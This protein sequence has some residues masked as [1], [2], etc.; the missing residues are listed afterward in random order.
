MPR[1]EYVS[2]LRFRDTS[3]RGRRRAGRGRGP[4]AAGSPAW[5]RRP[6]TDA[7]SAAPR[8][9][10]SS[11]RSGTPNTH[12]DPGPPPRARRSTRVAA[13]AR[14]IGPSGHNRGRR[15]SSRASAG[16]VS[17]S[18]ARWPAMDASSHGTIA[19][20]G[21]RPS[22]ARD[23]SPGLQPASRLVRA[24]I[25]LR[26]ASG[27]EATRRRRSASCSSTA[28]STR[29]SCAHPAQMTSAR[30]ACVRS[31]ARSCSPS[32]PRHSPAGPCRS[33]TTIAAAPIATD[34]SALP[35]SSASSGCNRSGLS[36]V[37]GLAA[38]HVAGVVDEG[39]APDDVRG[40]QGVRHCAAEFSGPEHHHRGHAAYS[41]DTRSAASG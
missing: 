36:D 38:G 25:A 39:D 18:V 1:P 26:S 2:E 11:D 33:A 40:R 28:R 15:A 37:E 20:P 17:A 7:G 5:R 30:G 3:G 6:R 24:A 8:P 35:A 29:S 32:S 31:R 41:S 16:A 9:G 34:G 14:T 23:T 27:A 22:T 12:A 21:G 19:A 13:D 4:P 10:T